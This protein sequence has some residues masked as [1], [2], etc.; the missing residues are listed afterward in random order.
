MGYYGMEKEPKS[1]KS[2]DRS[3]EKMG[4]EKGPNSTKGTKGMSGEVMP[5]GVNASDMSGERKAKLVGGVAMGM[6]DG[7][8]SREASHMGMKDGK[9]GEMKGSCSEAVCYDHKRTSYP[10]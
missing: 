7:I 5:K 8:G 2:S 10:E 9:L 1:A 4:T 3:G 6:A